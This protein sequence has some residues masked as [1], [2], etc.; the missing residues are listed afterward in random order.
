M[1]KE[2]QPKVSVIIPVYNG[3]RFLLECVESVIHQTLKEI[4]IIIV[5]DG[6][7]DKTP[8]IIRALKKKD[9]RIRSLFVEHSNAGEAR[10]AG[11]KIAKGDF[12]SFL[13]ADDI[14]MPEMLEK[15]VAVME[16]EMSDVLVYAASEFDM[17]TGTVKPM[18]WS[19][20]IDQCPDHSPFHP[21]EMAEL[22]LNSF[23]NWPWNKMFRRRFIEAHHIV[24]QSVVRTNDLA[25]TTQALTQAE[26]ISVLNE[27]FVNYR[28]GSGTSLQQTNHASPLA[29]WDAFRETKRRM[30][31]DGTF[32]T[33]EES[34]L[35]SAMNG[36]IYNYEA[37][38][39]PQAKCVLRDYIRKYAETEFGFSRFPRSF[40][41]ESNKYDKYIKIIRHIDSPVKV[42]V[43]LPS[44]N[45]APFIRECIESAMNQTM[46][47]IEIICV[48]AGSTDGT[49]EILEE[50]AQKDARIKILHSPVKSYGYQ[51]NMGMDAATG[52]YFAILETDDYIKPLMFEEL[53]QLAESNYLDIIKPDF[54]IFVEDDEKWR[55]FKYRAMIENRTYVQY[56][57]IYTPRDW[58]Y[59]FK[60][61]NVIWSG[62][63]DLAFLRSNHIRFHESPGASYQDNGFW[64]LTMCHANRLMYLERDY[65]MLRRDNPASSVHSRG[66]VFSMCEEYSYIREELRKEP[67]LE[68]DFAPLLALYRFKNYE[69][70]Y[71]RIGEEYKDIFL[72]RFSED[73][74]T[75]MAAGEI[76][77]ELFNMEESFRLR[78]ILDDPIAYKYHRLAVDNGEKIRVFSEPSATAKKTV[79]SLN[80]DLNCVHNSVSFKIG[81]M[82]TH[83]PRKIRD[84]FKSSGTCEQGD[85]DKKETRRDYDFYANL[86]PDYYRTELERWYRCRTGNA[87]SLDFP[88]TFNEKIQWLKLY[89]STPLKTALTDKYLVRKYVSEKIGEDYLVPLL[90][91][92]NKFDDIDFESLPEKFVLKTNHGC[93]TN[94]IVTDK[95][96]MDLQHA[97]QSMEKWLSMNYA[98]NNGLELHYM[99]IQPRIIAEEYLEN[100]GGDLK[101]YKVFCFNGK[102][103]CIMYLSDRKTGLR[104]AFFDLN[105]NKLD[106]TYS[107]P[108]IEEEIPC[109]PNL[110]KMIELAERLAA[111]FA[112]VRVDFYILNDGSIKFGEMTFTSASGGCTWS[113]E[114]A[115]RYFGD[116]ITLPIKSPIPKYEGYDRMKKELIARGR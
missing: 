89:D 112:H 87:L 47:E 92:W 3:E 52:E 99:N 80:Y 86:G 15:C 29:F 24:W 6:S 94:I 79:E 38:K 4:E 101:D 54:S 84:G 25:F 106:F 55:Y 16:R 65:Y 13:D 34:Y 66:K 111:G 70:N 93:A 104:M 20:Q 19:L 56:N 115:N 33:Y 42:S 53:Y 71:G 30:Q 116:L 61:N 2:T 102:A 69:W 59:V 41:L 23:Q 64:F 39:D 60:C 82:I 49:L 48:D 76:H 78:M 51:M 26:K 27:S 10:N 7:Q 96:N 74:R 46:Q 90:G 28:I 5:D 83:L 103:D 110:S 72:E 73:F 75:I 100:A 12:L 113:D 22:L 50:Y 91:A 36:V 57:R 97:E 17:R 62:I 95:Q 40:Y 11:M 1:T 18:P 14:F 21:S 105:W 9:S 67:E 37:I 108:R 77:G 114:T 44:L 31:E 107:Y 109:P 32:S 63:Y 81:R 68:K 45:V 85:V 88:K 35:R 98:F 8:S 58:H 43:V